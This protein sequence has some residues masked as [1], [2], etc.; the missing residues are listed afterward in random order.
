M[1]NE[2]RIYR[3]Q[4]LEKRHKQLHNKIEVLEVEKAPEAY[5]KKAK[6]EKLKVKD[7]IAALKEYLTLSKF[8]G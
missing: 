7:E 6:V 4:L 2:D 5:I 8:N 1:N 3:I